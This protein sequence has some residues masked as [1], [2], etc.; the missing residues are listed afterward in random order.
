MSKHLRGE[1]KRRN[2]QRGRKETRA[3]WSL[4]Y[5]RERGFKR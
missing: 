4:R 2:N 3:E 1:Q 5:K